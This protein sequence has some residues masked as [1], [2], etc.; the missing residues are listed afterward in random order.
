MALD[1]CHKTRWKSAIG[2]WAVM[3][4]ACSMMILSFAL[5]DQALKHMPKRNATIQFIDD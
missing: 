4:L 3:F 2:F 5:V 1:D